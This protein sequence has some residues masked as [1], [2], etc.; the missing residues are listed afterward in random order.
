MAEFDDPTA[1]VDGGAEAPTTRATGRWTPTRR[2]RFTSWSTP[3]TCT[4]I[5]CRASSASAGSSGCRRLRALLLGLDDRVPAEHRR[6][7]VQQLAVVHPGDLR[8]DDPVRVVCRGARMLA[9][10]GLPKP[11]HP[12][13]NVPRFARWPAR[14]GSSWRSKPTDPKFDRRQHVRVP[15]RRSGA[16][17]INEVEN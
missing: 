17:E 13:F 3:S 7:S 15:A 4:T 8:A 11:Y 14:T 6:P 16:R 5:A 2:S 10:N 9:L 1:L 12:V